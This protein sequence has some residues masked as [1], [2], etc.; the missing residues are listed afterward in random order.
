MKYNIPWSM[1]ISP[2]RFR[3]SHVL[4][5]VVDLSVVV[6]DVLLVGT[7]LVGLAGVLTGGPASPLYSAT[8]GWVYLMLATPGTGPLELVVYGLI[9]LAVVGPVWHWL[10]DIGVQRETA[11]T[12]EGASGET[13]FEF[14]KHQEPGK[15]IVSSSDELETP[16]WFADLLEDS[17]TTRPPRGDFLRGGSSGRRQPTTSPAHGRDMSNGGQP[18]RSKDAERSVAGPAGAGASAETVQADA[19]HSSASISNPAPADLIPESAQLPVDRPGRAG[20]GEN[21]AGA[22][23]PTE[24]AD[25]EPEAAGETA[26]PSPVDRLAEEV[27]TAREKIGTVADRLSTIARDETGGTARTRLSRRVSEADSKLEEVRDAQGN[28]LDIRGA[29]AAMK[30]RNE[31]IQDGFSAAGLG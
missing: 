23:R 26:T 16:A 2:R 6:A 15:A 18:V 7:V 13:A 21:D 30:A 24:P 1:A 20:T 28:A 9:L 8:I 17:P 19:G 22:E 31:A 10:V 11:D 25:Q 12:G 4:V 3:F 27:T 29:I 5:S 14:G